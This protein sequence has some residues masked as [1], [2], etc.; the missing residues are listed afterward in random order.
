L[1]GPRPQVFSRPA[2]LCRIDLFEF[3]DLESWT[4]NKFIY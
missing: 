4:M 2:T 1:G 3:I